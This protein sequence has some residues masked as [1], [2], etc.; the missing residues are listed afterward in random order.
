MDGRDMR[1][2]DIHSVMFSSTGIPLVD[3]MLLAKLEECKQN[4]IGLDIFVNTTIDGE[5]ASLGMRVPELLHLFGGLVNN[6]IQAIVKTVSAERSILVIVTYNAQRCLEFQVFDS[7]VLPQQS[8]LKQPGECQNA[9]GAAEEELTEVMEILDQFGVSIE[10]VP[11]ENPHDIYT[12]RVRV[13][14]DKKAARQF[15][16]PL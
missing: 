5:L 11:V 16:V 9:Q 14:F 15:D 2:E 8:D 10:A 6:A 4:N 12:R 3:L 13:C 1:E 7:G